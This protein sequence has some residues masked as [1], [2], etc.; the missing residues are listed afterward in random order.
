V[1]EWSKW[2][3]NEVAHT[4]PLG[5]T[6]IVTAGCGLVQSW[7]GLVENL[8]PGDVIWCPPGE[9]HWHG[10]MPTMAMTPIAMQEHVGGKHVEGR[11]HVSDEQ[12]GRCARRPGRV[13]LA[14]TSAVMR[15]SRYPAVH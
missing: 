2:T 10:A 8:Q 15:V 9:K 3:S 4:H 12:D 1:E 5:Q 6:L 11:E 13:S 14:G 7:G